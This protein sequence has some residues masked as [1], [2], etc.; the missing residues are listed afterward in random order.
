MKAAIFNPYWDSLGGGERYTLTFARALAD[1]GYK[2]NI[3]WDTSGIS[4]ELKGR[5]AIN[6]DDL[7]F[8]SDVKKGESYDLCFWVS[9]GSIPLLKSRKNILHFQIPFRGVNGKSLI[10]KMKLF[11][12]DHII[13]NSEFTKNYIDKE[14]GV[15]SIVIYPPV[16]T[17]SFRSKKKENIILYVGR[18]SQLTQSKNQHILINSFKRLYDS[19]GKDWRLILA[20]G[21]GVGTGDYV[22]ELKLSAKTYPIKI[23]ENPKL[24]DLKELYGSAKIFWS[25]SGFGTDKD[26]DPHKSEHFGITVVEAMSAK[27]VPI[28]YNGGGHKEIIKNAK[29]GYLWNT[30]KDLLLLTKDLINDG[31]LMRKLAKQSHLD[32]QKYSKDNFIKSVQ[33]LL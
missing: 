9:D 26:K 33:S 11:R 17:A 28:I 32:S 3:Q 14:F 25:A 15:D 12:I 21:T 29:N 4:D 13:C 2:V 23:I 5:F 19:D 10:N 20:G 1:L 24:K 31:I 8:V 16:D 30:E 22:K 7:G 6:L 18:F 27:C